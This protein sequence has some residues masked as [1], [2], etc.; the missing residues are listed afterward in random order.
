MDIQVSLHCLAFKH[1]KRELPAPVW[2]LGRFH[3]VSS[4]TSVVLPQI[5]WCVVVVAFDHS[6]WFSSTRSTSYSNF[7][8]E[9]LH[10]RSHITGRL[11]RPLWWIWFRNFKPIAQGHTLLSGRTRTR[12][13]SYGSH[14][15]VLSII[16]EACQCGESDI[17][18]FVVRIW[19]KNAN[20]D[21]GQVP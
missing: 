5:N 4:L 10:K 20:F 2:F 13:R 17:S 6:R 14:S 11:L 3:T 7:C 18:P 21:L 12:N 16:P 1:L 9:W 15:S 8:R 19:V